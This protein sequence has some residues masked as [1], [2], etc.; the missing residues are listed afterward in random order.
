MSEQELAVSGTVGRLGPPDA[1]LEGGRRLTET[2]GAAG[3]VDDA[4][5][6][7]N[8]EI[9]APAGEIGKAAEKVAADGDEW[10]LGDAKGSEAEHPDAKP[11]PGQARPFDPAQANKG[12][13]EAVD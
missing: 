10:A 12:G 6:D 8:A 11:V 4:T 1:K 3:E 5:I 7:Q 13:E 2:A 9:S